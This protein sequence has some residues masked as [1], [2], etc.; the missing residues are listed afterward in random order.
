M[1]EAF[2]SAA[3]R[4]ESRVA[5]LVAVRP[6]LPFVMRTV[7]GMAAL[8]VGANVVGAGVVTLLILALNATATHHQVVVLMKAAGIAVAAS[9]VIG[10]SVGAI[11]QRRTLRWVLRARTPDETDARRAVRLPLDMAMIAVILWTLDAVLFGGLASSIDT[12]TDTIFAVGGGVVLAG[13]CSAGITYLLVARVAQPVIR[14]ALTAYPPGRSPILS[15]RWRLLLVWLLTTGIPVLGIVLI[16]AAPP[17]RT[18]IRGAGIAAAC[19]ALAVGAAATALAARAI[20]K[21]LR[22][23]VGVLHRVGDG[24]LGVEVRVEDP[25]EI[26][27]LQQGIND[28]MAGLRERDRVQD[29]FGR[30]VGLS[31]AREA[32]RSGVTLSG[33]SR[34]VVAL[35]VDITGSTMLTRTTDPAGFVAMLNR[36]FEIVV[37]E[38]ESSGGLLNK[39][40]GDAALC[41]FGAP[42][43]LIDAET[44]ALR[45]A[46][47]IR[48]RVA[49]V[50]EVSVGVGVAA[51]PA[52]AGQVGSPSRLEYTV[53]GDAVNEAAR[54][55]DIAKAVP[56]CVVASESVIERCSPV[57]REHWAPSAEVVLRGRDVPTRTWTG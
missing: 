56:G 29:L 6:Q 14:M 53:I 31:V 8:A 32:L 37:D 2:G 44:S 48:D 9:V 34:R 4:V 47:A 51:G 19:V 15:V 38:V 22:D 17:E 49:A 42:V 54:L 10:V 33:E 40:E 23:A 5:A 13:M 27:Q 35:F 12:Q 36:F 24:D 30:H 18:H 21:P 55:T 1:S 16:L 3:R 39:F 25:G 46:R 45:T 20:G 11:V 7:F 50:G 28:M 26:G 57:E 52:I 43:E 41:V